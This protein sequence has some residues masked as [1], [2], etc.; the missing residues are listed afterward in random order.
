MNSPA[1]ASVLSAMCALGVYSFAWGSVLGSGCVGVNGGA[2]ELA[3]TVRTD[4]ARTADCEMQNIDKVGIYVQPC[5]DGGLG[6][7][8]GPD[9]SPSP[10]QAFDCTRLRGST[11]FS[12]PPGRKKIWI[13]A[14]CSDGSAAAVTV[15]E[16]ILREV[17][18][19]DVTEL[20]ALLIS[21]PSTGLAC[22]P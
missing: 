6:G 7:C 4:D 22:N 18:K 19:G 20:N 11:D 5:D 8:A 21:V 16:P 17:T 1:R 13:A 14:L 12:I 3:W 2:I 9:A 10:V 15:P